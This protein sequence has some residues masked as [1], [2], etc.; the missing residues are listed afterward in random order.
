MDETKEWIFPFVSNCYTSTP[1]P[2]RCLRFFTFLPACLLVCLPRETSSRSDLGL[3]RGVLLTYQFLVML[4]HSHAPRVLGVQLS[5]QF[6]KSFRIFS[7]LSASWRIRRNAPSAFRRNPVCRA[8]SDAQ[9][10][11]QERWSGKYTR[12]SAQVKMRV[13]P[14]CVLKFLYQKIP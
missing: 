3:F 14:P 12:P 13:G 2:S 10:S 9:T 5:I 6:S 8:S 4:A 7:Y 11:H 1:A